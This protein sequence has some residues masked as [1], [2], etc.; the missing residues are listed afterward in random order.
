METRKAFQK[1]VKCLSFI[2]TTQVLSFL[3]EMGSRELARFCQL[4]LRRTLEIMP[5][6]RDQTQNRHCTILS[7]TPSPSALPWH[8]LSRVACAPAVLPSTAT[9]HFP[10][11]PSATDG[12]LRLQSSSTSPQLAH[13]IMEIPMLR[14]DSQKQEQ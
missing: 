5:T 14:N 1:K 6:T 8:P 3:M 4:L 2:T 9:R 7:Q 10:R 11:P 12:P 13:V